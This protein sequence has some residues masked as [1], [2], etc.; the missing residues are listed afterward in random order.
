MSNRGLK[1]DE[2]ITPGEVLSG[3]EKMYENHYFDTNKSDPMQD[4]YDRMARRKLKKD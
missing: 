4:Y 3:L 1:E 2:R